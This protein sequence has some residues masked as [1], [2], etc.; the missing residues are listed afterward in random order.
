MTRSNI[1]DFISGTMYWTDKNKC[2]NRLKSVVITNI[3]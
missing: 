3:I 2:V 1:V